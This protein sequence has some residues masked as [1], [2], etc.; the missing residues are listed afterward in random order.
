MIFGKFQ[1]CYQKLF[2]IAC[3]KIFSVKLDAING[4]FDSFLSKKV[5][6]DVLCINSS[7]VTALNVFSKPQR[8]QINM[9]Y[10]K[11]GAQ[12][13]IQIVHNDN[14]LLFFLSF[15]ILNDSNRVKQA[16]MS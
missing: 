11:I 3:Y 1:N 13:Q 5:Y 12:I 15:R 10:I 6:N 4:L 16:S 8:L 14:P 9:Y 2:F 7:K